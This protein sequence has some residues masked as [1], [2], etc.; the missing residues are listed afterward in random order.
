MQTLD[1]KPWLLPCVALAV[2]MAGSVLM[3]STF[4]GRRIHCKHEGAARWTL[5]CNGTLQHQQKLSVYRIFKRDDLAGG[6]GRMG[7]QVVTIG[8]KWP[9]FSD[10]M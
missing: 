9:L 2:M 1:I 4:K 6:E 7:I 3:C 8:R 5:R 10:Y